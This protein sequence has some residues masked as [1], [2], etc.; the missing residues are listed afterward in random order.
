MYSLADHLGL[1]KQG[2]V[3]LVGAGGKTT[4]MFRLAKELAGK[5]LRVLTTTT[6]KIYMPLPAQSS[7]VL[8][9]E[10]VDGLVEQAI[11]ALERTSHVTMAHS[12]LPDHGK[13]KGIRPDQ[14][15]AL[16][17]TGLFDWIL[18]EADGSR[19]KPLKACSIHEPVLP[20]VSEY[21]I[22]LAGLDV[23]GQ[24]LDDASVFRSSLVASISGRMPGHSV[25]EACVASVLIRELERLNRICP[26]AS[27]R[28]FLNKADGDTAL[29]SGRR[30][31]E[32]LLRVNL[33]GRMRIVIGALGAAYP[34][35]CWLAPE[36]R[37]EGDG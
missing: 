2:V 13:L 25:D 33:P 21:G 9:S 4:L 32:M 19:Q 18:V 5:G 34:V 12:L 31:A 14:V 23:L 22:L 37:K 35:A 20:A 16:F 27:L 6:T 1:F 28:V 11:V 26:D 24:S 10:S 30:I 29:T 8:L 7:A 15:D 36:M 3:S 17:E